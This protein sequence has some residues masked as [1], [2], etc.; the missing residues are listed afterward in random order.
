M[1][2][3]YRGPKNAHDLLIDS[4]ATAHIICNKDLFQEGTFRS[5]N[6]CLE[7]GSGEVLSTEGKGS[8]LV[9][10]H[11]GNGGVTD[12]I[13]TNVLFAPDLKFNLISTIQLGKKGI[14]TYLM[15]DD[16]PAQ[17]VHKGKVVGLAK[18]IN[19]QYINNQCILQ[20]TTISPTEARALTTT[21]GTKA[22]IQ[23][24]HERLGHLSYPNLLKL[25]HLANGVTI[26]GPIPEEVC[27]SCMMG[28]QQRKINRTPRTRATEF[29]GIVHSDLGGPFPLT[30][31]GER[32]YT[33][34]KDDFSGVVWIYL[35][36]SKGQTFECFKQFKTWIE[37]QSG[38]K[39]KRLRA[40]GGGEYTSGDFQEF[41]KSEAIQWEAR[42]PNVPEQN[43]KAERQNYTLMV[44]TRSMMK[45]KSSQSPFGGR[46]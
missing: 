35:L 31:F 22:P 44:P 20:T 10:L 24:W 38:K 1:A 6:I 9:S 14:S 43:G 3:L 42:A 23:T 36:K 39:I 33:T 32:F 11:N 30:R 28:R 45:A 2:N 16:K 13:L 46:S 37:N 26:E 34:M 7:T 5:E 40:D 8:L 18:T 4:G 15:A 17:L 12:L 19:N 41:L 25:N 21:N 27:G 29:L